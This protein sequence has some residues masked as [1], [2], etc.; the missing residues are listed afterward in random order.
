MTLM[1][2]RVSP[3]LPPPCHVAPTLSAIW[4]NMAH[5]CIKNKRLDVAEHCLGK[6]ENARWGPTRQTQ[7]LSVWVDVAKHC[8]GHSR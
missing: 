6:M 7:M 3:G 5:L 8:L 1:R 4:E 2:S